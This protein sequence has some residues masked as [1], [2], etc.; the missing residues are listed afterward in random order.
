MVN[1]DEFLERVVAGVQSA[2]TSS[3]DAEVIW[4]DTLGGRQFDVSVRFKLGGLRYL[5][6]IEVKN[7]TRKAS[8]SDVEAFVQKANDQGANKRVF[9]TVA[10]FQT[11]A[12]AVARHHDV[13]LFTVEFDKSEF[14]ISPT[15]N[16][17]AVRNP[18]YEGSDQPSFGFSEPVLGI[19]VDSV[20]LI[21]SDKSISSLP[22]EQ[23]Q[24]TY[25]LRKSILSNSKSLWEEILGIDA[26]LEDGE[27]KT[28]R[29]KFDSPCM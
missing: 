2:L 25:Y 20:S 4:N 7:R 22:D 27:R 13:D 18:N 28:F 24:M 8:A 5:V 15:A 11:G 29:I 9:V 1:D 16:L 6:L 19:N 3:A 26:D 14:T 17:M 12:I 21:Y 23:S 10:G